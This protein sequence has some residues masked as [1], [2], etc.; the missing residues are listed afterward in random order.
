[1]GV[2]TFRSSVMKHNFVRKTT[3]DGKAKIYILEDHT[4]GDSRYKIG[5]YYADAPS[6]QAATIEKQLQSSEFQSVMDL[7]K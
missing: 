7:F 3:S 6:P 2:K 1:M 4:V 5:L